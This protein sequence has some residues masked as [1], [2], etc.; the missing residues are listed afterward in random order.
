MTKGMSPHSWPVPPAEVRANRVAF[1]RLRAQ[2]ADAF[3][4]NGC[5]ATCRSIWDLATHPAVVAAVRSL[6][7]EE[8]IVWGTHFFAK[9]PGDP[10][11]VAW[12]QDGP[13]WPFTPLAT[14]TAWI[15]IDD[16]DAGNGAMQVVPGSHQRGVLP[17]RECRP[18]EPSVLG[19]SMD[20]DARAAPVPIELRAGEFSLHHDLLIHGSAANRSSRRCCGLTVRYCPPWVTAPT[21]P[22]WMQAAIRVSGNAPAPGWTFP[23]RPDGDALQRPSIV[24]GAN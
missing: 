21:H 8:L 16:S 9:E 2:A 1:D 12:H 14:V 6:L 7:G 13:Y 10:R 3:A 11:T 20:L 15:A 4:I 23:P 17:W 18:D 24:I 19:R 22:S 5:H